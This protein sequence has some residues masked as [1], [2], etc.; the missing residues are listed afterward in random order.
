MRMLPLLS[1]VLLAAPLLAQDVVTPANTVPI[2]TDVN[3]PAGAHLL[4]EAHGDG[5]QIYLCAV[6]NLVASWQLKY[7]DA[8][9]LDASGQPI[10]THYAGPSWKLSDGS[11]VQGTVIGSKASPEDG[12][13][14]WLLLRASYHEGKGKLSD[15]EFIRRSDTHG[16]VVPT[17]GCARNRAGQ[18]A[19]VHYTATYSF[20]GK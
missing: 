8:K 19:H 12:S 3:P 9:L 2:T 4:F 17:T 18:Q 7:P 5:D 11:V 15:V 16:G 14:P 1:L 10:G 13:I 20:Y 6:H